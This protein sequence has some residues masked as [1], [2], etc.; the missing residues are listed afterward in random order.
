MLWGEMRDGLRV[1]GSIPSPLS[2]KGE[3]YDGRGT[4]ITV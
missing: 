4:K 1:G 3:W 2:W